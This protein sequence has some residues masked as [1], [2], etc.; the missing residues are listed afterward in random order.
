MVERGGVKDE[1]G[2]FPFTLTFSPLEERKKAG[3]HPALF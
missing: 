1:A 2:C 3:V